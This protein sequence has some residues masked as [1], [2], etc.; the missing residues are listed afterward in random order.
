MR[1]LLGIVAFALWTTWAAAQPTAPVIR[2]LTPSPEG[3]VIEWTPSD[4]AETA[5]SL[6]VNSQLVGG[7]WSLAPLGQPWPILDSQVTL[8]TLPGG[9]AR[10]YRVLAVAPADRGRVLSVTSLG[11]LAPAV[12]AFLLASEDITEITPEYSV[13]LYKIVYETIDPWGGRTIASG[14]LALPRGQTQP[15]PLVSYQ[16]GTVT[17][18]NDVPTQ[19]LYQRFPGIGLATTGYA[20]TLPDY[21]GLGDS[22]GLHPYHH[23]R[24]EAT[25]AIDLLRAAQTWCAT[26]NVSLSGQLFL[27]G[28]S[29][30]GHATMALHREL[31]LH[32]PDEFTVTASAPMA[33]AYDLSDT[34]FNDLLSGRPLPNPYYLAYLLAAYQDVYH[35]TNSWGDWLVE[36]YRTDLP[37]LIDNHAS[38][39]VINAAMQ[40]DP[41]DIRMIFQPDVLAALETDPNYPLRLA[42]ED[43]DLIDWKPEAPIRMYHC[44]N[45][46]D[47]P[48]A[49]ASAALASFQALGATQVEFKDPSPDSD[50]GGCVMPSFVD[51]KAWFDTFLR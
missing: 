41:P 35:L 5:Y 51:A 24:S 12:I 22:P 34:T 47:V 1:T 37:P 11:S 38:G 20:T 4:P 43:N 45:D 46:L 16:H 7:L 36:P 19:D 25:A 9:S 48:Y 39:D 14:A 8:D 33:G 2:H 44:S 13:D 40:T 49:N 50:H 26:H 28:Y 17:E 29:Q 32:Y 3:L 42:L 31:Q 21:L 18:T 23:A 27:C 15:L 30:G 6:Q 10:F